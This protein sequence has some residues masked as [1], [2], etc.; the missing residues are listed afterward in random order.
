MSN[1]LA[2]SA[3][4]AT[5]Q[6]FL[7]LVFNSPTA[8]LGSVSITAIAPDIVQSNL[9][10]GS[11]SKLQVNLFL[12]QVLENPAWR[13]I[14]YPS[15]AADGATAL[16]N[17]PLALDLH[18]LLS[19]YASEDTQAEALL[20]Y[21]ILLLHENPIL[22]RN[23]IRAALTNLPSTNPLASMLN[24]SGIADQVEMIKITPST[25]NREEMAWLWTA[26]KADYRPTYPFHVSVVLIEPQYTPTVAFPVLSQSIT[27][28]AGGVAQIFSIQPPNQQAAAAPGDTVTVSGQSLSGASQVALVNSRLGI[29]YP[30]FAPA[31]VSATSITFAVP[32]APASLPA[33][34]YT[35]AILFTSS[36]GAVLAS[37]NTLPMPIAPSILA[38][39][40]PSATANSSGTLVSLSCKPQVL[41]NQSVSLILGSASEPAVQFDSATAALTFQF[42]TL[43]PGTSFLARLSVDGVQSPLSINWQAS[44][45]AFEGPY[46]KL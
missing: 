34:N 16:H 36:T 25:L 38:T 31:T 29:A 7:N 35:V 44:P 45:P 40:T 27:V 42:P 12:H 19:A 24:G 33:G 4:T 9:G 22:P 46:L 1:A 6:Y 17:P 32:D 10:S 21:A 15:L 11:N 2:I 26:L 28:Q 18:Y 23:Q 13:N 43:T 3:V 5:L 37:T 14:G 41:P 30:P 39:P 20:G 8:V